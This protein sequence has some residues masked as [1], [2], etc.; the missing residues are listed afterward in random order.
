MAID[1]RKVLSRA[2][3][4]S[5]KMALLKDD[6]KSQALSLFAEE[7]I[8]SR[9]A[10]LAANRKDVK[11]ATG[12]IKPALLKRLE[13]SAEKLDAVVKMVESVRE[14][15]DPVGRVLRSTELDRGLD[16]KQVTVPLGVI[17]VVFES[18]PDIIPQI[19]SLI[20]KSGNAVVMKGGG[21]AVG[22]NKVF[23]SIW[24]KV[25]RELGFLPEHWLTQVLGRED[26]RSLL[27]HH[28]L[29]DLVV[30]RGSNA[31]VTAVMKQTLAPVLGHADGICALFVDRSADL[32]RALEIIVDAKL[33]APST[34]NAIETLLVDAE[35]APRFLPLLAETAREC[36][37]ELKACAKSRKWLK[38]FKPA[39]EKDF[40]TEFGDARLA[41]KVVGDVHAAIDHIN[42]HGSHHTDGILAQDT[43]SISFFTDQVDSASVMVNSSTRF[44]DGFRYGLGAEVGISTSKIHVRGPAGLE[45]LTT[46][47]FLVEGQGHVVSD[48]VG[49]DAKPFLHRPK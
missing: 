49:A 40:R 2:R 24:R 6:E 1:A 47:K 29:I 22:T 13:L 25:G 36:E 26:F 38:G 11:S 32:E 21:E 5:R 30:P 17:V 10:L 20:L 34:C 35:I 16:L 3:E 37:I 14:L 12:K 39:S 46:T 45:A 27:K 31:L 23:E 28:D 18:R 41:V 4:A 9:D 19:S 8:R 7:I 48:Y 44:A 43:R 33:Q 15:E 42:T